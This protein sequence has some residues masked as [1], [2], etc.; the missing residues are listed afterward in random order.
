[1]TM[2]VVAVILHKSKVLGVFPRTCSGRGSAGD[3]WVAGSP[4]ELDAA[5]EPWGGRVKWKALGVFHAPNLVD[6]VLPAG[7]FAL[8]VALT[9][10]V[11]DA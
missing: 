2:Q 1:M 10:L 4:D 8:H 6:Y 11:G 7:A 9:A 5:L 3:L